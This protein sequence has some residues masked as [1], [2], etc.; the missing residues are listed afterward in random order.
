M[1]I[2]SK[3]TAFTAFLNEELSWILKCEE[4]YLTH[5]VL[6]VN[7]QFNLDVVSSDRG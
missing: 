2:C 1:N 6:Q 4:Y 7:F 5:C 3:D